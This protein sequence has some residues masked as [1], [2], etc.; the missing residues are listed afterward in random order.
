MS[1]WKFIWN[2]RIINDYDNKNSIL[3]HLIE[4][5]GFDSP[6]GK[7][8]ESDWINY[9]EYLKKYIKINNEISLFEIGMGA[10]AFLYPFYL[11]KN[12]VGGIDFSEKLVSVANRFMPEGDFCVGDAL[13]VNIKNKYD[14]V[15]SN[16]VFFYFK[17]LNY[18]EKVLELMYS[19]SNKKIAILD[20]N[21]KKFEDVAELKRRGLLTKEEYEIK[22]KKNQ[23]LYYKKS[24]FID[25]AK[26]VNSEIII[27]DQ[28][29]NNYSASEYRFNVIIDKSK[30]F[31]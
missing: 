4:A 31:K 18:A 15:L 8:N 9:L 7:I 29:I 13:D 23:H 2:N 20:V 1:N 5:D 17:N 12:K 22:Y 21:E 19:K 28:K 14:I 26:K 11:G 10:G 3:G 25:F 30:N 16:S 27:F 6:T 24:F